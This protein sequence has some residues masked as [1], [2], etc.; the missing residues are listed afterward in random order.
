VIIFVLC[1]K[2][3]NHIVIFLLFHYNK[4]MRFLKKLSL[5]LIASVSLVSCG[6]EYDDSELWSEVNSIKD[7][8]AN[9]EAQLSAMNMSIKSLSTLVNAI[10]DNVYIVSVNQTTDGYE[11]V[12]SNGE[13][14]VIHNGKDGKDGKDG[15]DGNNGTSGTIPVIGVEM[16][17]GIYYWTVTLN[18]K[19]EFITDENGNKIP[20]TATGGGGSAVTPLLK[21]DY[22]GYWMISY[23]SGVTYHYILDDYGNKVKA[24]GNAANFFT[25]VYQDGE[26]LVFVLTNGTVIRIK[27]CTCGTTPIEDV[28]PPDILDDMEPYMHIYYG[29]NPPIVEGT[30]YIDPFAAVY[31]QDGGFDPGT[32]VKSEYIGFFNQDNKKLTLDF[33]QTSIDESSYETGEG[34]FIAGDGQ[35]FTIYFNTTG[36]SNG[37]S[38]KT[39]LV[40]SGTK[41]SSGIQN[42]EYAFVMVEKG[43]DPSHILMEEGVFRV[44]KDQDG[45]AVNS[46]YSFRFAPAKSP[47]KTMPI[48]Y[49]EFIKTVR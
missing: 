31:C 44:F 49:F 9:I 14:L 17:N 26:Y 27:S 15:A 2:A 45:M 24:T 23:D 48:P 32:I 33:K 38:T 1:I 36:A 7:R 41:T 4:I 42:L 13:R 20:A 25:D 6:G 11:I 34:S 39:A 5:A 19:T 35:N 22:D 30:Y 12:M 10:K 43:D 29:S 47:A 16:I 46:N 8:V 21:V 18:G 37:I 40:I 3:R 28:V